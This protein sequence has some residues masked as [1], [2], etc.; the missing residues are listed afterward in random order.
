MKNFGYGLIVFEHSFIM[1][2]QTCK[3]LWKIHCVW[4]ASVGKERPCQ[5]FS[6][7]FKKTLSILTNSFAHC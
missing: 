6:K 3:T 7:T 2:C 5:N 1:S 4:Q